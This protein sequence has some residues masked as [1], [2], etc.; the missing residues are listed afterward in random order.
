MKH[1]IFFCACG[2]FIKLAGKLSLHKHKPGKMTC[3][4]PG[5]FVIPLPRADLRGPVDLLQ[6]KYPCQ[7][8]GK[9]HF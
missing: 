8:M 7:L 5:L 9:G 1:G 3:H 4:F 6:Q 2:L